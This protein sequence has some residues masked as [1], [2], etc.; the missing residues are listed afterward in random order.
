MR[1]ARST[2][3]VSGTSKAATVLALSGCGTGW[4]ARK[5]P[6][7][8]NMASSTAAVAPPGKRGEAA[9]DKREPPAARCDP[10]K[11]EQEGAADRRQKGE[12]DHGRNYKDDLTAH[13]GRHL[14]KR[15]S[16]VPVG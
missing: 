10:H 9:R 3:V 6:T 12:A 8:E 11:P 14:V 5:Q 13:S 1:S 16:L 15:S 7:G 4:Q 2:A